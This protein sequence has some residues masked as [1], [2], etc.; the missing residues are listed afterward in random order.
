MQDFSHDPFT[1]TRLPKAHFPKVRRLK[2][3]EI[4]ALLEAIGVSLL[5]IAAAALHARADEAEVARGAYVAAIA[6][7]GDCHTPGYFLGQPDMARALSGSEVG[8]EVPGLGIFYGLN[9]TP[10]DA[11]GLGRWSAAEIVAA[12]QTGQRPDGRELAP[13]MRW[14]NFAAMTPEDAAAVAAYLKS[15]P[16][17]SNQVPGPFGAGEKPTS[18]VMRI[19]PPEP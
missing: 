6:G 10:D 11:T 5:V 7:C 4:K 1:R 3:A 16:P 9:L 15:L 12:L 14:R 18:F 17:V 8:F 13:V 2:P 19:I